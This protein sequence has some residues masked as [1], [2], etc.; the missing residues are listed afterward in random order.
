MGEIALTGASMYKQRGFAVDKDA[1]FYVVNTGGGQLVKFSPSGQMLKI[2]GEHGQGKGLLAEPNAVAVNDDGMIY[3]VDAQASKV[4]VFNNA[5]QF[6][7]EFSIPQASAA[8]GPRLVILKDGSLLITAP[9]PHLI[10]KYS[11]DGKLIAQFGGFGTDAGR[12]R[13]PTGLDVQGGVI[14]VAE[15]ANQRV[16]KLK[17]QK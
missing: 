1:N 8:V 2:I 6:A 17:M 16:Q 4:V 12:F 13:Q 3:V 9:E 5:G 14:W 11:S 7:F 15:T 10:Q